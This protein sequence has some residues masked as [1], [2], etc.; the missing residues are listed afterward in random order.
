MDQSGT[1]VCGRARRKEALHLGKTLHASAVGAITTNPNKTM[2]TGLTPDP[3]AT[4]AARCASSS[5][6]QVRQILSLQKIRDGRTSTQQ[7]DLRDRFWHFHHVII[8]VDQSV[9]F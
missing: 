2:V 7:A 3:K 9:G 4:G 5:Q 8:P 1:A 6:L